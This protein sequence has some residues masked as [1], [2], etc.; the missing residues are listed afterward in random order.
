MSTLKAGDDFPEGVQFRYALDAT[1][2]V[3]VPILSLPFLL[4]A[5]GYL[6]LKRKSPS[7]HVDFLRHTMLVKILQIRR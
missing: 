3:A 1:L 2:T 6:T 4:V 7:H 5:V